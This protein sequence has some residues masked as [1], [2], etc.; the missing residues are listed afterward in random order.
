MITTLSFDIVYLL[1]VPDWQPSDATL[2]AGFSYSLCRSSFLIRAV[3]LL[4]SNITALASTSHDAGSVSRICGLMPVHWYPQ[5]PRAIRSVQVDDQHPFT[6]LVLG[7]GQDVAEYQDWVTSCRVP[8]TII[9]EKGG[10]LTYGDLNVTA[11]QRRLLHVCDH[12]LLHLEAADIALLR[13]AIASWVIPDIFKLP[14]TVGGHGTVTPNAMALV[15]LGYN[16]PID[17]R[18][19][20]IGRGTGPYVEQIVLTTR[21]IL[22]ARA[23]LPATYIE[24]DFP[25]RPGFN[26]F[27]PAIYPLALSLKSDDA[28][29]QDE[30]R[31]T[32]DMINILA[33]Q[34]G[35][36]FEIGSERKIETLLGKTSNQLKVGNE[37]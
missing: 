14:Y 28:A 34:N 4:P 36:G 9:A 8:P 2:L 17:R 20:Q 32:Q 30:K 37:Y 16:S 5:S 18:F 7:P 22:D 26:L 6:V 23:E 33:T 12:L 31:C 25:R 3:S 1:A 35:Y 13:S 11:L 21:S 10:D 27:A 19:D 29:T 24:D 15:S